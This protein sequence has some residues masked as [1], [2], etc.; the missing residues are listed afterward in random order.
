MLRFSIITICLNPGPVIEEAVTSVLEQSHDE[1]EYIV[2]D[3]GSSDGTVGRIVKL[4]ETRYEARGRT[5]GR[6]ADPPGRVSLTFQPARPGK[7]VRV[8]SER[9]GG[10]YDALN[11]GVRLATGDVVG[12]VHADDVLAHSGVLQRV[13]ACFAETGAEAVYGDL[14]YVR[15]CA[16]GRF[17]VR[18]HWRSGGFDRR[19]L[20][21]GWMPPHPA[22]YLKRAVYERFALSPGVYF[23]PGFRCS[24]DY[25]LMMRVLLRLATGPVYVPDVL[26][27]MRT[28]GVSN[29]SL[30]HIVRK[31]WEDWRAI[32]RNRVGGLLTLLGKNVRKVGQFRVST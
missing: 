11:K 25:D 2:V 13:A 20:G 21:W 14:Q 30:K 10:L 1:V 4:L 28:G 5:D 26:V 16:D 17:E 18:R 12:F 9:D 32:R 6:E 23:D 24:G 22:L 19:K 29:R 27:R 7:V 15:Q 8:G 31:S 3:G